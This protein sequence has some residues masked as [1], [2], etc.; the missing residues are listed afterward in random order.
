[1][2][3]P[4]RRGPRVMKPVDALVEPVDAQG[5]GSAPPPRPCGPPPHGPRGGGGL[6][7]RWVYPP[8]AGWEH[9]LQFEAASIRE[10]G[11]LAA[12]PPAGC[13]AGIFGPALL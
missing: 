6:G 13:E 12:C 9:F 2:T 7:V 8:Q 3:S 5:G 11:F 10:A 4:G 1:M